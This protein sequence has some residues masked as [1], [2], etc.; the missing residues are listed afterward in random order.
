L[1]VTRCFHSTVADSFLHGRLSDEQFTQAL[2]HAAGCADCRQLLLSSSRPEPELQAEPMDDI[3]DRL[4][5][6]RSAR[7]APLMPAFP[8]LKGHEVD[9]YVII[10]SVGGTEDGVIYEAF[11][12]EREVRVVVKQLDLH[13]EDPATASLVAVAHKLCQFSHP[14]V[15]QMQ[16]VG[17]HAGFVYVV[18]EFVKGTPLSQVSAE[19]PRQ[20]IG[21]FVDAGAG[22]GAAHDAGIVH[23]C[24]SPASCVV[25]R[26]GKIKV[27]DFGVGEARVHRVASSR[28]HRDQDWTTANDQVSSEDSFV[29]FLPTRRHTTSGQ[30]ESIV[31]AAGPN[32]LG[33]RVYAAPELVLGAP[34][35]AASDQFSF[36][37]ALFHRLYGQPPFDGETIA[38]WLRELLKGRV[39][40]PP[41]RPDVPPSVHS[42]L[43]RGLER[44][45][46]ARFDSM[47]SLLAR[48]GRYRPGSRSRNR[49]L[50]AI[51][52]GAGVAAASVFVAAQLRGGGAGA[53]GGERSCDRSLAGWDALWTAGRQAELTKAGRSAAEVQPLRAR[54][55]GWV[56]SWRKATRGFC[57]LP[58]G[59]IDTAECASRAHAAASDLLQ[60]VD[61]SPQPPGIL[62]RAAA[63]AEALPTFE[64]CA[65]EAPSPGSAPLVVVKADLRRRLGLLDEADQLTGKP[66]DE[67]GQRSYQSL[68]RGH[69]AADRGDLIEARRLFEN[70]TFEAQAAHQ[71][72]LG[73]TAAVQRLS[74]SCSPA[75]RA[76][77]SGYVNAQ[78]QLGAHATA[79]NEYRSALAQSL[80]CEGRIAEAVSL[81]QQVAQALSRDESAVGG[82]AALDLARAQLAQNDLAAAALG[83]QRAATTYAQAYGPHHP[84]A[85]TARLLVAE[86]QLQSPGG[87]VPDGSAAAAAATIDRVLA[88][89]A[90]HKEPN[91]IRAR[92]LLVQGRLSAARGERDE[93]LGLVQRAGQECEAAL[94]GAHPELASALLVAG[95]L[96]LDAG[97]NQEA[98]ANYR[99]VAA[100]FDTLDQ[101]ESTQL[102]HAR[103]GIQLARWGSRPPAD[104][105]DT[106]HW[107]L[108]PTGD[109]ID[110]SVAGWL[111]DQLG[112]RA[113]ASGDRA[114]ALAHY[115]AAAVAWQQSGDQRG[116]A[117][118]LVQSATL[119]AE[120]RDPE[121]R[122]LLDQALQVAGE[123]QGIERPRLQGALAKLLWPT[124]R[125]RA[126]A[127]VRAALA[128]L[129]ESAAE[130]VELKHWLKRHEADR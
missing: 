21:L 79:H 106:L 10:R 89:L 126:R 48:L 42:A 62:A 64:Q 49:T 90:D 5:T 85:Q 129:P 52:V 53:L 11:D 59:R 82:A 16:S 70:A 1:I 69:T 75:E 110:P 116:L 15:L 50:A 43:L 127:L 119:A 38:L 56:D 120:L 80:L 74:L 61:R 14:N 4:A 51:A 121:A 84:L 17:V 117:S 95:D 39:A 102:A 28:T 47:T 111:A 123:A 34:P 20:L 18:Y 3:Q 37:A 125:D 66:S 105:S 22:L 118:A 23:G 78:I 92:A 58:A 112:R 9:R 44:D 86:A 63:A 108:A 65:S 29:G 76:L 26:D 96:L 130:A 103:A 124:Q 94:G 72:D 6:W 88:D 68:V 83:A 87:G 2:K 81:R 7:R 93:A 113:A 25:G 109:E 77:W 98:E 36:C 33:P 35:S 128:D 115:R 45:P 40:R 57:T 31:L 41:A 19:D 54:L 97:R 73:V 46:A 71:P 8:W 99:Q 24:F 107:G 101:S 67:L 32:S 12:P 60:L 30:F 13:I 122:V 55:D 104:A 27:L 100:I 114:G 91:A